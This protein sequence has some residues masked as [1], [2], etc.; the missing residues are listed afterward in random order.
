[1]R[2]HRGTAFNKLLEE[3]GLADDVDLLAR[4]IATYRTHAPTISLF[5]DAD[6]ALTR[7]RPRFKLGAITDGRGETQ[8]LKIDALKLR[9]RVDKAIITSELGADCGKPSSRAFEE[10]ARALG[11]DHHACVYVGDNPTKDFVAPS[12]LAWRSVQ[13]IRPGGFYGHLPTAPCGQP[14]HTITTLDELDPCLG[15]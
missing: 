7:L 5:P 12:A 4:M 11:V 1:M 14:D 3:R 10:I 9:P 13:I 8:S 2:E 6:A 15:A